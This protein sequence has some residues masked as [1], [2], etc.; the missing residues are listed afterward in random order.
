ML[1]L[2]LTFSIIATVAL[3]ALLFPAYGN[4]TSNAPANQKPLSVGTI[5]TVT[6]G[7]DTV[8][9]DVRNK[10][11]DADGDT[12][13]FTA[14]AADTF[15]TTVSLDG[16]KVIIGPCDVFSARVVVTAADWCGRSATQIIPVKMSRAP[17]T[18]GTI[19]P[20]TMGKDRVTIDVRGKFRDEDGDGLEFSAVA[21][22]TAVAIVS[23]DRTEVTIFSGA[24]PG[25]TTVVVIATDPSGLSA[26]QTIG[27]VRAEN[28]PLIVNVIYVFAGIG[29]VG[30]CIPIFSE[31]SILINPD[32]NI[33]IGRKYKIRREKA[34]K[35]RV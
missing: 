7:R 24:K 20:V 35:R 6:I 11:E 13:Y 8:I 2:I 12:L 27:V 28:T 4:G 21:V 26:Q 22:D 18:V 19:N 5:D 9:V 14:V 32:F 1:K 25:T 31:I 15:V 23:V 29:F 16:S 33:K 30:L 34:Q 10:F 17:I 3:F